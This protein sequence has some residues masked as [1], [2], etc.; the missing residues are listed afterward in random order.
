GTFSI[1]RAR[2]FNESEKPPL[3]AA[4]QRSLI[5]QL[6]AGDNGARRR[7]IATNM[8]LV[9]GHAKRFIDRGLAP[10][11]LVR[12][13]TH[14]LVHALEKFEPDGGFSFSTYATWCIN[15]HIERALLH[16]NRRTAAFRAATHDGGCHGLAA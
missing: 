12:E 11:D 6:R 7:L 9:T 4:E 5:A 1:R 16:R 2:Y 3:A 14:A 13:G 10:L 15:H 8:H